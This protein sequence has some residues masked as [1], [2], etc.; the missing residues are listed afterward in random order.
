MLFRINL[1]KIKQRISKS[2]KMKKSLLAIILLAAA[3]HGK[4]QDNTLMNANFWK[5]N[6]TIEI[7]KAEISKGHSPSQG[8]AAFFDPT[9]LAIN[10]R[11]ANEVI[12]FLIEQDGNGVDKKTHHSRTYLQWAAA[13]GNLE[14]VN[15]LIEK[16]AD[17]HY[18]DSHGDAVIAYAAASGNKNLTVY[19]ALFNAGVDPSTTYEDGANLI[20]LAIANDPDLVITEYFISKGLTL[21]AKDLHGRTVADYAIKLGNIQ[22]LE[23][24]IAKGIH[25]TDQALFFAAQGSRAKVNGLEVYQ[26]LIETLNLNPKVLNPNGATILHALARRGDNT[27]INY[28]VEKG[29]DVAKAD[30]DGNTVLMG[31]SGGRNIE[32]VSKILSKDK[33]VNAINSEGESALTKAISSG[34]PEIVS[35]LVENGADTKIVDKNGN[36]LGSYLFNSFKT[37]PNQS[38]S[39]QLFNEKLA[40]LKA[41]GL[42]IAAPQQ[43]GSNLFHIAVAKQNIE[44]IKK[45]A[46]LGAD[47]NDQDADGNTALHQAALIAKDDTIL[48]AL[49][50]L[51]AKKD[52]KT[53]FEETA[54]DLA[55][56]NEFLKENN[57]SIEFLKS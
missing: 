10:N 5:S 17:V 51:G 19:E 54:F 15:Y 42:D 41:Q 7:L 1:N 37:G 24:L 38:E 34:S 52:T 28:F 2:R 39:N 40:L 20:M 56:E 29:V 35:L 53:E 4:A 26:Y 13:S 45:A 47:I 55:N 49:V 32:L 31:L 18:K 25:P 6:P 23:K 11:A 50:E 8:N 43:D 21:D 12:K 3:L 9:T 27:L 46:E 57:V 22:L 16:G 48:K 44:L 30:N 36:N 33:N 14:I